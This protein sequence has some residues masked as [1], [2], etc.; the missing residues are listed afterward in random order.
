[1]REVVL[2]MGV[3]PE[4]ADLDALLDVRAMTE[5]GIPGD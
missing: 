2:E 1:V 4:G 3:L 5:P